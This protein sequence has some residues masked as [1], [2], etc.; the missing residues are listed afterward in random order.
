AIVRLL[1]K[2]FKRLKYLAGDD[3]TGNQDPDPVMKK[4]RKDVQ[5]AHE[6]N[7]KELEEKAKYRAGDDDSQREPDL[8][9]HRQRLRG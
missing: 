6:R 3:D 8:R 9:P 2:L 1:E 7:L 5:A 4:A